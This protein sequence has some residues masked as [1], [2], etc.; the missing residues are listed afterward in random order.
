MLGLMVSAS[1]VLQL[2]QL[3]MLPLTVLAET[4]SPIPC[5]ALWTL[6]YQ[7]VPGLCC[8]PGPL[9]EPWNVL[10]MLHRRKVIFTDVSNTGW[11]ALC[12]S[13]PALGVWSNEESRVRINCLEI[14]AVWQNSDF[15]A[16]PG[17]T[18]H[19]SP[20][21]QHDDGVARA[22][23]L[24]P[25]LHSS[26][27]SLR[28]GTVQPVFTEGSACAWQTEPESRHAVSEQCTLGR[29]YAPPP[30]ASRCEPVDLRE[31]VINMPKNALQAQVLST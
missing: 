22:I 2:G 26:G 17:G 1:Q 4:L 31:N 11:G 25:P 3:H 23:L 7:G 21:R 16:T 10:G 27:E 18:P 6:T 12:D 9:E 15:S 29:M 8:G 14:L 13:G 28:L 30:M 19:P 20:L 24:H 5:L